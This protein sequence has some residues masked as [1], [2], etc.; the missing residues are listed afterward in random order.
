MDKPGSAMNP[1][2]DAPSGMRQPKMRVSTQMG[3][4]PNLVVISPSSLISKPKKY[5]SQLGSKETEI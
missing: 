3:N 5:F 4:K 1:L 2:L